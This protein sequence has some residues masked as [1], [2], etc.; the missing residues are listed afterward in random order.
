ML[1]DHGVVKL[2]N[3]EETPSTANASGAEELLKQL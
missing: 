1:V 2:I 3:V